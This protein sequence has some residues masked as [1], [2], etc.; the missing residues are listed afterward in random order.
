M[1][2]GRPPGLRIRRSAPRGQDGWSQAWVPIDSA[3]A[4]VLDLLAL[5]AEVEVLDP[6]GLRARVAATARQIAIR[7]AGEGPGAGG[8]IMT[9]AVTRDGVRLVYETAG[10]GEPPVIFVHGWCCDRSFFAPQFAHFAARHAVAALDLRGHG[11]SGRAARAADGYRIETL[12]SDVLAVA[13]AAGFS[14]PVLAGHSLGALIG[15]AC[16]A[17]PGA[18]RALLMIDPAPITNDAVKT[19]FLDSAPAV[20]ADG[21]GAWRGQFV[22]SM[23]LPSDRTRRAEIIG[24]M[25]RV[26]PDIAAAAMRAMGEFDGAAALAAATVPVLSIGSAVPTNS[27]ADLRALCPSIT[28][29]QTVGSGHFLQLQVPD[30]VNA[31][32]ERFLVVGGLVAA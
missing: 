31:M 28:I 7:H 13:E 25:A 27:S 5:G 6:P 14:Q 19:F 24:G 17:Q 11:E 4:T 16:A 32:M 2:L 8:G 29:G 18:I 3:D 30:Q 9:G 22:A 23:F 26:P 20:A 1:L 21:D 10:E 12:A 15:L